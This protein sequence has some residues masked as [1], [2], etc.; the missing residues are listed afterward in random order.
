MSTE[1]ILQKRDGGM[2]EKMQERRAVAPPVDIYENADEVLVI[3]DLPGVAKENL[4]IHLDKGQLTIDG[5]RKDADG[6]PLW[7]EF[8]SFDFRR[9]FVLP[10]GI[11]ADQIAAELNHG[12]L[13]VHLPKS[14]ALKPRQIE[15]K[16]G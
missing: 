8:G 13:R 14:A 10:P 6:S 9:T 15:V 4:S 2:P 12:V 7:A 16:A 5:Q 3:A 11:Q 1:K